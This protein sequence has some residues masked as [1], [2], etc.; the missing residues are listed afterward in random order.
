MR[1][2]TVTPGV[3]GDAGDRMT[4]PLAQS[5][6]G[7]AVTEAREADDDLR[8]A[9]G[10]FIRLSI[11]NRRQLTPPVTTPDRL[12]G[13]VVAA[14][15]ESD[16]AVV[17]LFLDGGRLAIDLTPAGYRGLEA[18]MLLRAGKPMVVWE[19]AACPQ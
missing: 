11:F 15:E 18:M 12:V 13:K 1:F 8:L 6:R 3:T 10:P 17:I 5:L 7:L 9:F 4:T 19:R 2:A 16:R 14:V